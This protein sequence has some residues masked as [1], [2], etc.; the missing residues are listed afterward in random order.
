M[1]GKVKLRILDEVSC[2]FVGLHGDH[3]TKLYEQFGVHVPGYFFQPLFKLGRWD[4]KVRYFQNTGKTYIYLLEQILP[5]VKNWGYQVEIEDLRTASVVY[6]DPID[7]N[8]FSH[9]NHAETGKPTVLREHQAEAVNALINNGHGVVIA[10]TGAG[11]TILCASL[12]HVYGQHG[13]KTITIVPSQDLIKQTKADYVTY[14]G[15]ENVGEYSGTKKDTDKQHVVSTWQALKNNPKI[16]QMFQMV[17]VDECLAGNTAITMADGTTKAISNVE[18][19]DVVVTYNEQ[20]GAYEPNVVIKRHENLS[21]S[22]TEKMYRLNFDNG[23]TLEVTGN[24]KILTSDGYVRADEL[25][26]LHEV[27]SPN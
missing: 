14:L 15:A 22:S 13:I 17:I 10:A 23:T 25:T 5:K 1:I 7:V 8:L 9:I 19:G 24:H 12:C 6:P 20:S 11:K 4:G 16:V 21:V 18:P 27:L 2:I 26:P 3:I